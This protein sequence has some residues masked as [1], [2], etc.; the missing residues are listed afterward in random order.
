MLAAAK[1]A[2]DIGVTV[3]TLTGPAPNPLAAIS[4]AALCVEAP[5]MATVQ[6]IHLSLVHALCLALD[7][8]R[9]GR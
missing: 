9:V 4:D 7:Q 6:E 5:T 2:R 8:A 3:W 1:A